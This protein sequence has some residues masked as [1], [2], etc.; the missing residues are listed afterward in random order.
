MEYWKV[1]QLCDDI[2][3]SCR[4]RNEINLA[5][6]CNKHPNIYGDPASDER[7]AVQRKFDL[8]KRKTIQQ[9]A[10]FLD[11]LE[12]PHGAAT[13]R[14]LRRAAFNSVDS[15]PSTSTATGAT[16]V[17]NL[18]NCGAPSSSN[19]SEDSYSPLCW[20]ISFSKQISYSKQ[21]VVSTT[22]RHR[23]I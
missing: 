6:I 18:F 1:K 7:R 12:L 10:H 19:S 2:K 5:S 11:K 23:L 20:W 14:E 8:L 17:A 9:Y 13:L 15:P 22:K 21:H 3:R 4:P 16:I